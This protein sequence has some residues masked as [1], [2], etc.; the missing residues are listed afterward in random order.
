MTSNWNLLEIKI[1][2]AK[3]SLNVYQE[4]EDALYRRIEKTN[5]ADS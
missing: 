4:T 2:L 1:N 3:F 5:V